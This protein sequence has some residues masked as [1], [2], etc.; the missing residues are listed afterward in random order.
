M[1]P[2]MEKLDA[3]LPLDV[4][5]IGLI[6]RCVIRQVA[7]LLRALLRQDMTFKGVLTLNFPTPCEL[8][9]LLRA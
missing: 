4:F 2:E 9:A 5:L 7:L 3:K 1:K 8:E 6:D